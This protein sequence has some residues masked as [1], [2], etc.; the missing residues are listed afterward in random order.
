MS[1]R[2]T[3]SEPNTN[4]KKGNNMAKYILPFTETQQGWYEIEADSL[5][6][7]KLLASDMD[8]M[9]D[10]EPNYKSGQ[11]NWDEN[12]VEEDTYGM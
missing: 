3:A 10:L 2:Y 5:E 9:I 1:S 6:Q 12:D 8:Y 7:A 11:V 4:I